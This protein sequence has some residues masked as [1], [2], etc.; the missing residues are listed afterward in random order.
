MEAFPVNLR[1][2]KYNENLL[3]FQ[4]IE[5]AEMAI[6]IIRYSLMALLIFFGPGRFSSCVALHTVGRTPWTGDQP[7]ARP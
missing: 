3:S 1:R 6:L 5:K 7:V 4:F 2:I